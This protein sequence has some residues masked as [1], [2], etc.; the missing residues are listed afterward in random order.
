MS[1]WPVLFEWGTRN[2]GLSIPAPFGA[3]TK[4]LLK[5]THCSRSFQRQTPPELLS[6]LSRLPV[7]IS[8]GES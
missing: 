6:D 8:T 7:Y 3:V 2:K 1:C 4:A 5:T